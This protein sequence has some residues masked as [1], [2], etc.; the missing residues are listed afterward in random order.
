MDKV[1]FYEL[2]WRKWNAAG[3]WKER[4]MQIIFFLF[5]IH[6]NGDMVMNVI[7]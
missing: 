3:G 1:W 6:D 4:F 5:Y 7:V 2:A